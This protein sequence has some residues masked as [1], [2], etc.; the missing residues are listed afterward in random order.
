MTTLVMATMMVSEDIN[1]VARDAPDA[2]AAAAI[3]AASSPLPHDDKKSRLTNFSTCPE[4]QGRFSLNLHD[5][6]WVTPILTI[7]HR[8][9][10]ARMWSA[11]RPFRLSVG[12][13]TV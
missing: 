10:E 4:N 11:L 12:P 8:A 7:R 2:A 1:T 13:P 9:L 6:G 3:A 5:S